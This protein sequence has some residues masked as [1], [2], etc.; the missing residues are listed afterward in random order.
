MN[1]TVSDFALKI[2]KL[3]RKSKKS[4]KQVASDLGISQS[5]LSHY[6]NGIRECGLD[7]LKKIADYY[8]VS[9]DY[10]LGRDAGKVAM[11]RVHKIEDEESDREMSIET[12]CKITF[13]IIHNLSFS[14]ENKKKMLELFAVSDYFLLNY[15]IK[16]GVF[17]AS[18]IGNQKRTEQLNF[19]NAVSIFNLGKV[20]Q[21]IDN[22]TIKGATPECIKTLQ[23]YVDEYFNISVAG[24]I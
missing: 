14:K 10:L 8:K 6:E 18:W 4:Q 3:R 23:S 11:T 15:G 9:A 1:T 7:F 5:L 16:S 12:L 22:K 17:P 21:S 20:K 13:F 24:L 2:S 19:L